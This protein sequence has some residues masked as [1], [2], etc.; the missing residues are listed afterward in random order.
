MPLT[1]KEAFRTGFLARC[2]EEGLEPELVSLRIK[3]A[4]ALQAKADELPAEELHAGMRKASGWM[5]TWAGVHDLMSLIYKSPLYAGAI[6]GLGGAA[7]GY[8]LGQFRNQFDPQLARPE[9]SGEIQDIQAAELIATLN[10]ESASA[11]RR[12]ALSRRKRE[13]EEREPLRNRYGVI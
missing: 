8:G 7:A 11:R 5:P 13:K 9:V 1:E 3:N 12:A 6:G 2:A 10:R 4:S